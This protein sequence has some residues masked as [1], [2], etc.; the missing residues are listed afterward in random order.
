MEKK[1]ID[2]LVAVLED[3]VRMKQPREGISSQ[4]SV[5]ALKAKL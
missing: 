4:T 1:V 5:V 3:W 2:G